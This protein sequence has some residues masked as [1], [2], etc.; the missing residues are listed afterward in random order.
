MSHSPTIH[1]CNYHS[2]KQ[3]FLAL[4]W[5]IAEQ[6]LGIPALETVEKT[7]N[8]PLTYI[9]TTPNL[10]ATQHHWVE[11]LAGFTFSI[12]YQKGRDNAVVDAL[13]CVASKLDAEVVKF[14]LDGVTVGTMGSAD[15][16]DLT[17][18]KAD[19]RIHKQVEETAVQM[20][21]AHMCKLACDGLGGSTSRRS[22]TQNC[23]GVDLHP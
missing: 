18:A 2:I 23:D 9:L 10:D 8:N 15:V 17:V 5:A 14:I 1:E 6:F 13:S 21:A 12:E 22:H 7:D 11:S 16:H 4:K 3:E 19:E 20:R